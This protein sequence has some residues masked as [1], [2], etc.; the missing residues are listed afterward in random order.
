MKTLLAP[1]LFAIGAGSVLAQ[2]PVRPQEFQS[3]KVI[4]T[5]PAVFPEELIPLYR[6]GG[7]VR[8]EVSVGVDG[9]VGEWLVTAHT[10][11]RFAD[12]AVEALKELTFEPARWQGEPVPVCI[13]LNFDFEVKGVVISLSPTEAITTQFSTMLNQRDAYTTCTLRELDRIP[14][15]RKAVAPVYPKELADLGN[16][17]E[18]SVEF[19]ID[20]H[21]NVRMPYVLGRPNI[22]LANLAVDAV[23]QWTFEPPTRQ[24]Q[25]VLVH[26]RQLFRFRP[27]TAADAAKP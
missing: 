3:V 15:P 16:Q 27:A 23:R 4:Q 22:A 24:G 10:H 13:T 17:G 1:L 2:L 20:E 6:N 18:I 11:Q 26:V 9:K 21:G 25:P 12:S 19:F 14:V 7:H 5:A 8:L